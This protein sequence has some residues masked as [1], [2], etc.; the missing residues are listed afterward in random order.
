MTKIVLYSFLLLLGMLFSQLADL[1]VLE[2]FLGVATMVCLSYIMIE[3]GLEFDIDK[4]NLSSYGFDYFIAMTASVLPWIFCA[5]YFFFILDVDLD[6]ALLV[7]RFAAPTS[8]GVLFSMLAAVGLGTTWLFKKARILAI[9]EDLDTIILMI[10]LQIMIVG[11]RKEA[12]V[13][14]ALISLFF[15]FAYYFLH[16]L[17]IPASK[18]WLL[19]YGFI[20]VGLCQVVEETIQ[21]NFEVLLPAFSF[22]CMLYNPH[23]DQT[24]KNF[25]YERAFLE[26][27]RAVS[28]WIDYTVKMLFMFLVGCSLPKIYIGPEGYWYIAIHVAIITFLSNLGKMFP[29]FCYRK[30]ASLRERIALS[31]AMFPRGEVGVGVLLVALK[32]ELHEKAIT[33]GVLSLALNLVL[34]GFFIMAVIKLIEF[35]SDNFQ[36][37]SSR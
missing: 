35:K 32:Y 12:I 23:A 20:V 33:L 14:L 28:H 30:E 25:V 27:R 4:K 11:F 26:S 8:A 34:T 37:K 31:V 13:L 2:P 19:F 5:G 1:G 7:G 6:E 16:K 21:V 15:F 3:V 22:G 10:P 17:R 36:V 9:F 24:V 29:S 18:A